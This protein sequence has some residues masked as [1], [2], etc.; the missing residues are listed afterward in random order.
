MP[1]GRADGLPAP[2][3]C[4]RTGGAVGGRPGHSPPRGRRG[5]SPQLS[6]RS[7]A[8]S[9]RPLS[10]CQADW[11]PVTPTCPTRGRHLPPSP[12][13]TE[14]LRDVP[15]ATRQVLD[16]APRQTPNPALSHDSTRQR[17][18]PGL[19]FTHD[20]APP[21]RREPAG[22]P[23][24]AA[25]RPAVPGARRPLPSQETPSGSSW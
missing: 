1:A 21:G 25:C 9:E 11:S 13:L 19:S 18:E 10:T 24:A 20:G 6:F 5:F 23:R 4:P 17:P 7:V 8:A 22:L 14:R 15:G 3:T 12:A 2:S 16:T